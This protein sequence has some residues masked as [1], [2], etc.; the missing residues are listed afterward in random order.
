MPLRT[1][2]DC[3]VAGTMRNDAGIPSSTSAI[4]GPGAPLLTATAATALES[5]C[6]VG[7][8]LVLPVVGAASHALTTT[9][10][11]SVGNERASVQFC[12]GCGVVTVVQV[13]LCPLAPRS[14]TIDIGVVVRSIATS[15]DVSVAGFVGALFPCNTSEMPMPL[16][17]IDVYCGERRLLARPF[18]GISNE[19]FCVIRPEDE[20]DGRPPPAFGNAEEAPPPPHP[21]KNASATVPTAIA[22]ERLNAESRCIVAIS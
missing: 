15:G 12:P 19:S 1:K 5:N 4:V 22:R 13:M 16:V 9:S 20:A 18:A 11:T 21:A 17:A 6:A 8:K 3:P 14:P 10:A 7:E 2:C